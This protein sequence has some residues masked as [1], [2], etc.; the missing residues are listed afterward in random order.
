MWHDV[1]M[2]WFDGC[3]HVRPLSAQLCWLCVLWIATCTHFTMMRLFSTCTWC[4]ETNHTKT[5]TH[6]SS[7]H[8]L[9]ILQWCNQNDGF[10][11]AWTVVCCI[12]CLCACLCAIQFVEFIAMRQ[13]LFS[14]FL[15]P[16]E[17]KSGS[18]LLSLSGPSGGL[19]IN[20]LNMQ[21]SHVFLN[22]SGT[23]WTW[24]W[25]V[26]N[27]HRCQ[28]LQATFRGKLM[29]FHLQNPGG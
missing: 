26:C 7:S 9:S 2:M 16:C 4:T 13:E 18:I 10:R 8:D 22:H 24:Y 21:H 5:K 23:V 29:D 20:T 19:G 1:C 11:G 15:E 12:Y 27:P 28:D 25:S 17:G 6:T 14:R 3:M